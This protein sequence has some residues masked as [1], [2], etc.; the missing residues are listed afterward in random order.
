MNI[1][2]DKNCN[3]CYGYGSYSVPTRV[4][5]DCYSCI[6]D[7]EYQCPCV[8]FAL[9]QL[10]IKE[11]DNLWRRLQGVYGDTY[12]FMSITRRARFKHVCDRAFKRYQRRKGIL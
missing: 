8:D 2:P 5:N 4:Y 3:V 10:L 7:I 1:Q 6:E 12:Y 11:S 9:K